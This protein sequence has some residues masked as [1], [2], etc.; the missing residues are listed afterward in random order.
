MAQTKAKSKKSDWVEIVKKYQVPNNWKGAWQLINSLIPF[1][2]LWVVMVYSLRFPYWVT[3][4]LAVLNAGFLV[5][6]FI[7]QHD[8][9]HNSFL[10][11]L[12]LNNII[13]QILGVITLTP[14]YHWRKLH[15]KHHAT[16]GDLDFRGFGDIDTLTVEEYMA[17]DWWGKFTYRFYRH[18]FT[19]FVIGPQFVFFLRHRFAYQMTKSE[20]KERASVHWTNLGMLALFLGIGSIIG[21][22]EYLMIQVPITAISSVWGVYL[23]YVQHQFEDT[24]WRRHDTW[25]YTKAALEGCSYF[26]LPKVLQWFSGNIGF[27]HI[28]H[29]SP[30]IPNYM[31]EKAHNENPIFQAVETLSIRHSIKP[32]FLHLWDEQ[33][34]RLISFTEY[35]RRYKLAGGQA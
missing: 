12:K 29:L 21:Y 19:I 17:R 4:L 26:K 32:I 24:Y 6:L 22:K 3:L 8:C 28:H 31:L 27:H 7:I 11:S 13:G 35:R 10:K 33:L 25:D 1:I 15:A 2:I 34:K 20:K 23:F 18:P 9:G 30:L 14:Y 5:R 16:S